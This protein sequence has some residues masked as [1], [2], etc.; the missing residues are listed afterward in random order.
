VLPIVL[1]LILG[2]AALST[3]ALV[4]AR[5]ELIADGSGQRLARDR[6]AAESVLRSPTAAEDF[7][8]VVTPLAGAYRLVEARPVVPGLS[9][10]AI[11]WVLHPD[12]VMADLPGALE[13]GGGPVPEGVDAREG[14][15][16]L[17][18]GALLIER[19]PSVGP[20]GTLGPRPPRLGLLGVPELLALPGVD[21]VPSAPLPLLA[22]TEVLRARGSAFEIRGGEARGLLVSPGS[23][24]LDGTTRFTGIL[25]VGGDLAL[26]G[27]ARF[28]GVALVGGAARV[29]GDA[30]LLGC[31]DFALEVLRAPVLAGGH[32]LPGGSFLGRY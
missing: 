27:T 23:L 13:V 28:E 25:V 21:L 6:A 18:A 7:D 32:P 4:L 3:S 2:L 17:G 22:S 26:R 12:S 20:G 14:C 8:R 19:V 1:L 10:F 24:V 30:R 11:E 15:T 5:T 9:Y 16:G 29:S 31:S